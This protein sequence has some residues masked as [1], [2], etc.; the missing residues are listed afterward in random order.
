MAKG[1]ANVNQDFNKA[2]DEMMENIKNGKT[3]RRTLRPVKQVSL[4][5]CFV[6]IYSTYLNYVGLPLSPTISSLPSMPISGS[7][8]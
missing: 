2:L 7:F 4:L 5:V 8:N 6:G 3:L 1:G